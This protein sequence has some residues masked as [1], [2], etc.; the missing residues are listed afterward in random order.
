[1]WDIESGFFPQFATNYEKVPQ[2]HALTFFVMNVFVRDVLQ[3]AQNLRFHESYPQKS[4]FEAPFFIL[5]LIV[6]SGSVFVH[7]F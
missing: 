6:Q 7:T 2:I 1:M 3:R 5:K 4:V